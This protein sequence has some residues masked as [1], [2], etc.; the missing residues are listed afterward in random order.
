MIAHQE[1]SPV[2]L[3]SLVDDVPDDFAAIVMQCLEKDPADRPASADDLAR[4]LAA[5]RDAD[6]WTRLDA[7]TWWND[8]ADRADGDRESKF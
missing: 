8:V 7:A 5:C 1:E 6:R 2:E 4:Q 3:A